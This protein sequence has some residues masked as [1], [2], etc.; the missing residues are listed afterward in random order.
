MILRRTFIWFSIKKT[1]MS[2]APRL[3]SLLALIAVLA[4]GAPIASSN[5]LEDSLQN[6]S[7]EN[8]NALHCPLLP[9]VKIPQKEVIATVNGTAITLSELLM[10]HGTNTFPSNLSIP[11]DIEELRQEYSLILRELIVQSLVKE[12][13]ANAKLSIG[14]EDILKAE[15][16]MRADY[17]SL[18][19][20]EQDAFETAL[21]EE[22]IDLHSWRTLLANRLA[23][24][25][26]NN[27]VL[28]GAIFI[29]KKEIEEY[30][31]EHIAI[32]SMEERMRFM[33][34]KTQNHKNAYAI[35]E[36]LQS[37]N[38]AHEHERYNSDIVLQKLTHI[39][40]FSI[41]NMILPISHIPPE[42][43]KELEK[44]NQAIHLFQQEDEQNKTMA[45]DALQASYSECEF[46]ILVKQA[47]LPQ[48]T[49]SLSEAYVRIER[50]LMAEKINIAFGH[51]LSDKLANADIRVSPQL[52]PFS[53]KK[54]EYE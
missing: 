44:T 42:W 33:I 4:C 3:C 46:I 8:N 53:L 51:W 52:F 41:E 34:I 15:R 30:Y 48:K 32:F 19:N 43:L 28:G 5:T 13:L 10:A 26:F 24:E 1:S 29:T 11:L 37:F 20:Q 54:A 40:D 22:G 39:A 9:C 18:I 2:L 14:E 17:E 16:I 35:M 7:Q 31:Q 23:V 12:D 50:I 47:L 38:T 36:A 25:R 6:T 27:E 45:K 21:L 49:L